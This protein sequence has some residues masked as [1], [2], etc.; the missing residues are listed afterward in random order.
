M[1]LG[2]MSWEVREGREGRRGERG[3]QGGTNEI[4][5]SQLFSTYSV[6][7]PGGMNVLSKE[8]MNKIQ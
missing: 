7:Y 8:K 3:G 1:L 2:L 4:L 5:I 6:Y